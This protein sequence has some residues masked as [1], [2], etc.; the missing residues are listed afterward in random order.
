VLIYFEAGGEGVGRCFDCFNDWQYQYILYSSFTLTEQKQEN[1][2][3]YMK[4]Y[5]TSY[6]LCF[7]WVNYHKK[8]RKSW[9]F[10]QLHYFQG[11]DLMFGL[12]AVTMVYRIMFL[13][14]GMSL[15]SFSI[16]FSITFS[17]NF[18]SLLSLWGHN[19]DVIIVIT[20]I[21]N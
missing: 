3:H 21:K 2:N 9:T 15:C 18:F 10:L 16:T 17:I 20:K 19:M 8:N 12:K 1:N 4:Q 14:W 7:S 6:T 13:W 5:F 11:I